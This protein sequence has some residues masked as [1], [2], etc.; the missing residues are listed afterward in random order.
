MTYLL[1]SDLLSVGEMLDLSA[2]VDVVV[3]SSA[4]DD[5]VAANPVGGK[6][7]EPRCGEGEKIDG[8]TENKHVGGGM[9]GLCCVRTFTTY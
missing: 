4:L 6:C 7:A 5:K 3:F 9:E 8:E 2:W 1:G